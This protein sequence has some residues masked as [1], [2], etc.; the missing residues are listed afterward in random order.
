[1][2]QI[3]MLF[4]A[5]KKRAIAYYRH[6]AEDKQENSVPIQREL[7]RKFAKDH[8]I[9]IIHE[10]ADEGETGLI[11]DRQGFQNLLQNWIMNDHAPHFDFVLVRAVNRWGR[12]QNLNE[13]AYYEFIVEQR[14]A[15]VIYVTQG[16]PAEETD[17]FL[18]S[19]QTF[20]ERYI[21]AD[22]SKKLSEMVFLGC[23]K[24]SEQG[25]S[26]GGMPC[27]GMARLLLD[28]NKNPVRILQKG[29]H[30]QISNER[31]TFTPLND[32]TTETVHSIFHMFV[33][34]KLKLPHI[35]AALNKKGIP[36][37]SGGQWNSRK[38]VHILT[39]ETYTGTRIY[40]K[41]WGKLHQK[42]RDNP[43]S[44]WVIRKDAFPAIVSRELYE[45]AQVR[46]Q[47]L[48]NTEQER[49]KAI[50]KA[51][52]LIL[53]AA[54]EFL[55]RQGFDEQ[56]IFAICHDFP[57]IVSA[58]V[59]LSEQEKEWYFALPDHLRPHSLI[60]GVGVMPNTSHFIDQFFLFPIEDF[61]LGGI[62]MFKNT[63]EQYQRYALR[64]EDIAQ[65]LLSIIQKD[66]TI[67]SMPE[68][69]SDVVSV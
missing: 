42:K 20:F 65:K 24:V 10:E 37:A 4:K 8:G 63:D 41:T 12:F 67:H 28:T 30:K 19:I 35:A 51:K 47:S 57:L 25:Y 1:M 40:N 64:S 11:A 16:M 48:L 60:I 23:M 68:K 66:Y 39:N 44:E 2:N 29:E 43:R 55:L 33:Q 56:D 62:C 18:L 58:T 17:P 52:L 5:N 6:S 54:N 9:K 22:F 14:G 49:E 13:S 46:L 26:A 45:E 36:S 69:I 32:E 38:I 61:G 34:E 3:D 7:I 53:K 59:Q 31:V 21:A 27:Y 15:K 50:R